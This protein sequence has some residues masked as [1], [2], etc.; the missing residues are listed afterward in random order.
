MVGEDVSPAFRLRFACC[1]FGVECDEFEGPADKGGAVG[2]CADA[3]VEAIK[4]D[5]VLP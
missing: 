4:G 1:I 5:D 2:V 3:G